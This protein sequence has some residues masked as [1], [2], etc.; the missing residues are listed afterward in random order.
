MKTRHL[1]PSL[2]LT[3][4]LPFLQAAP[5]D[6]TGPKSVSSAPVTAAPQ[7]QLAILLDTSGSMEGLIEQAKSQLWKIVNEF[8]AA[9]Q[10]G[11]APEVHVALYEYGNSGLKAEAGWVRLILPLTNDLDAVSQELFKLRTNG[12]EEYCGW[13]IKDAVSQLAWSARPEDYKAIFIAGNEP[14][15]QGPV[16]Y[17][18]SCRAAIA[19]GIIVNTIHCG[20]ESEGRN[21]KWSDAPLLAEGKFM[22][23]DQNQQVAHVAA[24]QDNEI[25][26]LGEELNRTYL[27]Y[28]QQ[29]EINQTRQ[30]TADSEARLFSSAGASVQRALTKA[31]AV[32]C[33]TAWDLVDATQRGDLKIEDVKKTDLP[34]E[35]RK[36]T[37]D[38][39]KQ[40]V[41]EKSKE[42]A[43]IQT[44]ISELNTARNRYVD[45]QRQ[46]SGAANTLD[47]A[48]ADAVREQAAK[49]SFVFGSTK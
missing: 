27:A 1:I 10:D 29:A 28:G 4:L 31:S 45:A 36:L 7:V 8:I 11:R 33:N 43:V 40:C 5:A 48:I 25:A 6:N 49:R 41:A 44:K 42:R 35:L 13:V 15:T 14:F 47:T 18:A 37:T 12:G 9:K 17:A 32:Y 16:D 23:I 30:S 34:E 26:K 20:S 22:T 19:K 2:L 46:A 24:P 3:T 39:L 38:Q 21:G